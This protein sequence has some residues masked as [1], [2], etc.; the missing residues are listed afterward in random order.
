MMKLSTEPLDLDASTE[1]GF[2]GKVDITA[3]H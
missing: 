1:V 3:M 2:L